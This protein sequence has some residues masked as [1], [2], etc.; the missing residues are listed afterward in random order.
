M[1]PI[2]YKQLV[3][4]GSID[5]GANPSSVIRRA[6]DV[7]E[8]SVDA[9]LDVLARRAL[10]TDL[11]ITHEF[12]LESYREAIHAGLDKKTRQSIKV[13]FRPSG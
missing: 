12:P 5:H 3:V 13:T 2:W 9:A 10:P 1:T 4:V 6:T 11:L 7:L 8:H